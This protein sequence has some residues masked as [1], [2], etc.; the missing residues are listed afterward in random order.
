MNE[1][2]K[3]NGR[4]AKV[5][6]VLSIRDLRAMLRAANADSKRSSAHPGKIMLAH[7]VVAE[8]K[9]LGA[10]HNFEDGVG[11]VCSSDLVRSV[12]QLVKE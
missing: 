12:E 7:C 8:G 2:I 9:L 1:N 11:H 4:P 5:A 3:S 6:V 10:D